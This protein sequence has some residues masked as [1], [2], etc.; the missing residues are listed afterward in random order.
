LIFFSFYEDLGLELEREAHLSISAIFK[1]H[2]FM[3][4]LLAW[5]K[6]FVKCKPLRVRAALGSVR[7]FCVRFVWSKTAQT[8]EISPSPE[9]VSH[10][11]QPNGNGKWQGPFVVL[12]SRLALAKE[13]FF[14]F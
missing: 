4:F 8:S 5:H 7:K 6:I 12:N 13:M 2:I 9:N 3:R 11:R 10:A 1:F 14:E